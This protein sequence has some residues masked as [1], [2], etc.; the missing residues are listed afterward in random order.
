MNWVRKTATS[1][2]VGMTGAATM[3]YEIGVVSPVGVVA[4]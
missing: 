1:I 2:K 3:V 4:D